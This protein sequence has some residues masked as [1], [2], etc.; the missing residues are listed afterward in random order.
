MK[1]IEKNKTDI[2]SEEALEKVT[3]GKRVIISTER[4]EYEKDAERMP[5]SLT[6][7]AKNAGKKI[8]SG[9]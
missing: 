9:G 1:K 4:R 7:F 8:N 6:G 3:G 2:L 5:V